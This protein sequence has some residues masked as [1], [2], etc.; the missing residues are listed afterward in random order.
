MEPT[1]YSLDAEQQ[2]LGMVLAENKIFFRI[3]GKIKAEHFFDPIHKAIYEKISEALASGGSAN[4][5]TITATIADLLKQAG[6]PRNYVASLE[7]SVV[8]FVAFNDYADHLLELYRRR[9]ILKTAVDLQEKIKLANGPDALETASTAASELTS[10][11]SGNSKTETAGQLVQNMIDRPMVRKTSTGFQRLDTGMAGGLHSGRFYCIAAKMKHGKTAMLSS[12]AYNA[13]T[14]GASILYVALEMGGGQIMERI[15]ARHI[16]VNACA[17]TDRNVAP[18]KMQQAATFFNGVKL[19]FLDCPIATLD[20]IC[21]TIIGAVGRYDGIILDYIQL[22]SGQNKG[23]SEASFHARVA[24]KLAATVKLCPSLWLLTAAQL[25]RTGDVRGSDGIRMA[26]D[27]LL[28]LRRQ[29][30]ED[31]AECIG[32]DAWMTMEASR[33]TVAR[34]IGDENRPAF[35]LN[36]EVGPYYS[37]I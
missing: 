10:V 5:I 29:E 4:S 17:I 37:G 3:C 1:L 14:S 13:A 9:E 33:Y 20:E 25:N 19:S 12:I 8:S 16:G 2:L 11:I 34:N 7:A 23:E 22:I 30:S 28:F 27:M 35:A 6:Q 31:G 26:A 24:Q 32:S 36:G 21:A 15:T 18:Q